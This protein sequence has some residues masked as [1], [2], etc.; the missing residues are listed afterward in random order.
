MPSTV[1]VA[2]VGAGA[3]GIAAARAVRAAGASYVVLEAAARLGGRALTDH[4]LGFPLDLGCTWLHSADRNPLADGDPAQYDRDRQAARL[5]LDDQAR[6][7]NAAEQSQHAAYITAC[8]A[9]TARV[10]ARGED[11]PVATVIPDDPLY[12]R[13]FEWWCGAYTSVPPQ[14][15]SALDWCRYLDTHQNWTVPDGFGQHIIR[16]A[17]GLNIRRETPVLAIDR[18]GPRLRLTTPAGIVEAARVIVTAGTEA[19]KRIRFLP[20]LPFNTEA[21]IHRLPLGRANKVV[22]RFDRLDPDWLPARSG[23][24]SV[25]FG[26]F[27]RP[28]AESFVEASIARALEPEGEAAQIAFVLAQ[29]EAMY[30]SAIRQRLTGARA[31][32][33]GQ[34]PWIWGAYSAMTP[35]GGDPRADLAEPVDQRLFF[36]GE[37]IHPIFCTAAHG[38]W[39]S[40]QRAAGEATASLP[41]PAGWGSL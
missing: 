27:G 32:L 15:L 26:R 9:A 33:W 37:A 6:W 18:R 10:A 3:A 25:R 36:A 16:R 21:A 35:G 8:E 41:G 1:D 40:G 19:L 23:L 12:R 20:A 14:D 39:E 28:V 29:L 17:N 13:H 38:A 30:G 7:A 31:S 11:P 2:I 22:M 34:T 5:F 24:L 4:S